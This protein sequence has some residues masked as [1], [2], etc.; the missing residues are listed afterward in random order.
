MTLCQA[1]HGEESTSVEVRGIVQ[2]TSGEVLETSGNPWIGLKIYNERCFGEVAEELPG[3]F[4]ENSGRSRDFPEA[5]GSLTPSQRHAKIVSNS[6]RKTLL[7]DGCSDI[8]SLQCHDLGYSEDADTISQLQGPS[9]E[10]G[11]HKPLS[12]GV[13]QKHAVKSIFE[14]LALF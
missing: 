2:G 11:W 3:K 4:R 7:Q 13:L 9:F 1:S 14:I 6:Q 12:W 5:R 10:S 8:M